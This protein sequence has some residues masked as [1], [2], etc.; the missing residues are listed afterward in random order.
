MIG[1][2]PEEPS[3]P[4][5]SIHHVNIQ[6]LAEEDEVEGP[7]LLAHPVP[8]VLR[9]NPLPAVAGEILPRDNRQPAPLDTDPSPPLA[10]DDFQLD[11]HPA[12]AGQV[13]GQVLEHVVQDR[14]FAVDNDND[15][16]SQSSYDSIYSVMHLPWDTPEGIR[17]WNN[18]N[19]TSRYVNRR[20]P[21]FQE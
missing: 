12:G 11:G 20:P 9:L 19:S 10:A 1:P 8:R 14:V 4:V 21:Y 18:Y 7:E 16:S 17:A 6:L 3:S 5:G 15:E 13:G 2:H